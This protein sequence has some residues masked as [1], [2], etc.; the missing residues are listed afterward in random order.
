MVTTRTQIGIVESARRQRVE[1]VGNITSTN[2][3]KALEGLDTILAFVTRGFATPEMYR[4]TGGADD[5]QAFIDLAVDIQAGKVKRVEMFPG[6][7]YNVFPTTPS[8]FTSLIVLNGVRGVTWNF[9]GASFNVGFTGNQIVDI[10]VL[11]GCF[12]ITIKGLKGVS[13]IGY[14]DSNSTK[15]VFWVEVQQGG[16]GSIGGSDINVL[17]CDINGGFNG[18]TC[19]RDFGTGS[20]THGITL[21]GKFQ[22]VGYPLNLQG[23]GVGTRF[24]IDCI[25]CGRHAFLFNVYDVK[26][27]V[28]MKHTYVGPPVDGNFWLESILIGV[29]GYNGD[30]SDNRISDIDITIIDQDSSFYSSGTVSLA[31]GQ[32]DPSLTNFVTTIENVRLRF[33]M[34]LNATTSIGAQLVGVSSL[35][36]VAGMQIAHDIGC[37]DRNIIIEGTVRGNTSQ[38]NL[39]CLMSQNQGT[40]PTGYT[41]VGHGRYYIRNFKA[42]DC[43]KPILFGAGDVWACLD[44]VDMPNCAVPSFD[45]GADVEKRLYKTPVLFSGSPNGEPFAG[46]LSVWDPA[47]GTAL[48]ARLG[49]ALAVDNPSG[50][51]IGLIGGT[52]GSFDLSS[53]SGA[54]LRLLFGG[55]AYWRVTTSGK[56]APITDH[57]TDFGDAT[58][59]MNSG[60][61]ATC[62]VIQNISPASVG[63]GAALF[64][65]VGVDN[66]TTKLNYE[67]YGLNGLPIFVFRR[68]LG[69]GAAPSVVTSGT[70]LGALVAHGYDGAGPWAASAPGVIIAASED[71]ASGHNGA[72]VDI[73][74]TPTGTT[75]SIVAARFQQNG[76]LTVQ[77]STAIPAGGGQSVGYTIS[78]TANFGVFAGS[79]VP[80]LSAAQGSLYMRSDG[81]PFARA[82]VN[83]DGGA[84]YHALATINGVAL[85]NVIQASVN[86][87]SANTD[88]SIP[89]TIPTGFSR[90]RV[91]G[92]FIS[93]ASA[94]ISTATAGL[95]TASGGGGTAIVTGG[96]ALTVTTASENTNNNM[97]SLNVN[98]ST[99]QSYNAA[100]L[101]FRV[102]T[103]QGSA[104]TGT[105]E[106]WIQP[107]S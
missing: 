101:F 36:Y 7:V 84:T 38:N 30:I 107:V 40:G 23:D 53:A 68:A 69:T 15:G 1:Q 10:F 27:T 33:D 22:N 94:S 13:A 11:Q 5:T 39:M 49:S 48:R 2:T 91:A 55:T 86:F 87:N 16:G 3:Q 21:T 56:F 24:D 72:R 88:T 34:K 42:P 93:G 105:V 89:I 96:S 4:A 82:Y 35:A 63:D 44:D 14:A 90:Y 45:A 66:T 46:Y 54:D 19:T 99:S 37:I 97:M 70:N 28:R 29:D 92:V 67:G 26:G 98:N 8:V 74:T 12:D 32:A 6:R 76:S 106:I 58:H 104:A 20:W 9:N 62:N 95:F 61:F 51:T 25:D 85:L 31:H 100:T 71:F 81:G 75:T 73:Q 50:S 52:S 79:G 77:P 47:G 60:W 57:A 83:T 17:D 43:T 102:G 78:S 59:R 41:G 80:T 65:V 64:N 103:P 18:L